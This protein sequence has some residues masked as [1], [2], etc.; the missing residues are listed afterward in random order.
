M[1]DKKTKGGRQ[2]YVWCEGA[3]SGPGIGFSWSSTE[4]Q[5][6]MSQPEQEGILG[7]GYS[8]DKLASIGGYF[9]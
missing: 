6:D 8:M 7:R 9:V 1:L 4:H 3:T 2:G 5:G